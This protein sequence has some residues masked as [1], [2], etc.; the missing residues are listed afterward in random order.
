MRRFAKSALKRAFAVGLPDER[1]VP[2]TK[3]AMRTLYLQYRTLVAEGRPLPSV[4]DTGFRVFSQFD[5]D[6]VIM[7]LLAIGAERTRLVVEL[8]CGDG[9]YASNAANLLLNLGYHGLLVDANERDVEHA[10]LF[11]GRHPDSKERPP[12]V[13]HAFL[14][15]E[16]V[17][18]VVRD[19]GFE[20]EVDLLSIDVDGNDYWL[21]QALESVRPRLVMV[22]AHP[23][24]GRDDYVMPYDANFVWREAE[25]GLRLGAS[26]TAFVRLAGEL[27]FRPVG[28]NLY[29]FNI[30]FARDDVVPDVP[31]VE[32]SELFAR[33][34]LG[35]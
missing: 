34:G 31:A 32:L 24:L 20:G 26:I 28:S 22:E 16:N 8:G 5:E 17:N 10:R 11:Y 27:G 21:W 33:A 18:S 1:T 7:F 35:G 29:G 12:V 25:P 3:I 6:G 14:T 15:R 2:A 9:V 30:V 19:A 4:W 23:Q 13:A